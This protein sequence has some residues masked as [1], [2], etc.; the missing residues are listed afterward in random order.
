MENNNTIGF[1]L[2]AI[3]TEQFAIVEK[4]FDTNTPL[5]ITVNFEIGKDDTQK[6]LSVLLLSKFSYQDRAIIILDCSCHFKIL[7]DSWDSF[8]EPE[9]NALIMPKGFLTHLAV[10]AVGTA[11]G[12]LHSKT[13]GTRFNGYFLPTINISHVF[14]SDVRIE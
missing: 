3:R 12:I 14:A 7:D 13:E 5:E 8:K 1:Q 6:I 11:R 4:D 9:T 2:L 10:I